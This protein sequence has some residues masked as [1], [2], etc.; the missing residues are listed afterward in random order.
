MMT[1]NT[2]EVTKVIGQYKEENDDLKEKCETGSKEL[3]E[4][5]RKY[6]NMREKCEE[7]D[8]ERNLRISESIEIEKEKNSLKYLVKQKEEEIEQLTKEKENMCS[9]SEAYEI[10]YEKEM[11]LEKIEKENE[12]LNI[13]LEMKED[14]IESITR[15]R[16]FRI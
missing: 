8:R 2:A 4:A 11:E 9:E 6:D 14:E 12:S 16:D 3:K 1:E 15:E 7:I 5:L 10:A 13:L